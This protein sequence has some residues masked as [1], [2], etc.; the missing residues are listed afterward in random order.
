MIDIVNPSRKYS[1]SYKLLKEKLGKCKNSFLKPLNPL[2]DKIENKIN[3]FEDDDIRNGFSAVEWCINHNLIQ[4]GYT[5]LQETI[6][7]VLINK[8]YGKEFLQDEEK[9]MF[10]SYVINLKLRETIADETRYSKEEI[11]KIIDKIDLN[12]AKDIYIPIS[13][14]RNDLNHAG[15][16]QNIAK[17]DDLI[18]KLKEYYEKVKNF[19]F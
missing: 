9:R 13:Q 4:Q 10:I 3:K 2:F 8:L 18:K 12:F 17:H 11:A 1:F 14:L 19:N 6:I 7:S 15:C 16:R 5:L